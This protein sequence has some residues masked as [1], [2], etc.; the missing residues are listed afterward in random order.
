LIE[1]ETLVEAEQTIKK[2]L[3]K[4]APIGHIEELFYFLKSIHDK[5]QEI[6]V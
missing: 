1:K 6:K 5:K 3:E 2:Y 4:G